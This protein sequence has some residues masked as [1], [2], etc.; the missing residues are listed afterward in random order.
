MN[1]CFRQSECLKKCAIYRIVFV[2]YQSG[3]TGIIFVCSLKFNGLYIMLLYKETLCKECKRRN[4]P[5]AYI[6][7]R[8]AS[9]KS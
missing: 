7:V 9:A 5:K 3:N 6:S 1:E 2:F 4:L 8:P